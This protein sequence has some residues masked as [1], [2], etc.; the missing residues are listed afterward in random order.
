VSNTVT[1]KSLK[2]GQTVYFLLQDVANN[3]YT[4]KVDKRF[5]YGNN[6]DEPEIG[7]FVEKLTAWRARLFFDVTERHG[8]SV[9]AYY[10]RR[11][12]ESICR[13]LNG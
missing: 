4:F 9:M 6:I 3:D 13:Q 2:Q 8:G 12:A 7:C 11:K 5:L 10:S 1:R